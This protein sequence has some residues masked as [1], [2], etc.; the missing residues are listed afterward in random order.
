MIF[1]RSQLIHGGVI[2]KIYN[3]IILISVLGVS[4]LEYDASQRVLNSSLSYV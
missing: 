3:S 2:I 1:L 4:H